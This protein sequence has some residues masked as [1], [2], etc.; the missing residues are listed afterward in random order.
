MNQNLNEFQNNEQK[1]NNKPMSQNDNII[2]Q[3]PPKVDL[4]KI[5][6]TEEAMSVYTYPK[7]FLKLDLDKIRE[8]IEIFEEYY[9]NLLQI[10]ACMKT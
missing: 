10:I 2:E 7:E 9:Q 8:F 3:T 6:A 1:D 4:S 5:D